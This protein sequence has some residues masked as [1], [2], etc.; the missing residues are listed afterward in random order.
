MEISYQQVTH[1][2]LLS[3]TTRPPMRRI[4]GYVEPEMYDELLEV[5]RLE[6][7]DISAIIRKLLD[8]A[9]KPY[10][11]DKQ[12]MESA[13]T[14]DLD[15]PTSREIIR[16]AFKFYNDIEKEAQKEGTNTL[17]MMHALA[18]FVLQFHQSVKESSQSELSMEDLASFALRSYDQTKAIAQYAGVDMPILLPDLISFALNYYQETMEIALSEGLDLVATVRE[19]SSYAMRHYH[20][21]KGT[22]NESLPKNTKTFFCQVCKQETSM[23]R[24]HTLHL[25]GEEYQ[26]CEN[27]F[28]SDKYIDFAINTMKGLKQGVAK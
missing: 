7:M 27:C 28:F 20:Y 26:G 3:D 18:N 12:A 17:V 9:L 24:R 15:A 21:R 1:V 22:L 6:G 8:V 13:Q 4:Y 2:K 11:E 19:L 10:R 14:Y 16:F 25:L 5:A 23:R